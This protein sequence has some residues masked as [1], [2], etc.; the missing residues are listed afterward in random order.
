M[1]EVNTGLL[2]HSR[3]VSETAAVGLL[4]LLPGVPV[5]RRERPISHVTSPELLTGVDCP[6]PATGGAKMRAIGTVISH[7]TITGGHVLQASAHV[8]VTR[9]EVDRRLPWSHYLAQPGTVETLGKTNEDRVV[10]GFLVGPD[11]G[12]LDLGAISGRAM[13]QVLAGDGIDR[14]PPF[15]TERARLRWVLVTPGSGTGSI[16]YTLR[17]ETDRAAR[18][19]LDVPDLGPLVELFEELA[20]HDW[21]LT[22]LLKL[23]DR[24]RI[25]AVPRSVVVDR[26][27]PAVDYLL[28]LWMPG[29]R[30]DR[31][32]AELWRALDARQGLSRQWQASVERIRDQLVL[33]AIE[34]VDAGTS[35]G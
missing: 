21:L 7:A 19:A 3:A 32:F 16:T 8:R 24:G 22:T 29:A 17:S 23:I 12:Q 15:K 35:Q 6:L 33:H 20:L 5:R 26:L 11:P 27:R 9:S 34:R 4:D 2:Q 28:H 10:D 14:R 25:G 31:T 30:T 13:D 18:L 1:G